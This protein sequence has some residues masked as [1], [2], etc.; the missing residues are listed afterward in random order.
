MNKNSPHILVVDDED[1]IRLNLE[2]FFE[3][4]NCRVTCAS[5]AEDALEK[6]ASELFDAGIIDIRLPDMDGN[7]LIHKI[8][9]LQPEMKFIIHTGSA[10]YTLP[11][12]LSRAGICPRQVFIKPLSDMRILMQVIRDILEPAA[13]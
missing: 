3:D 7:C 10:D 2:A 12:S 6:T 9:S 1:S 5:N 8:R 4:E 11:E 13:E